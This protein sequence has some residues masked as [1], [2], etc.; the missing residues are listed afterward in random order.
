M[1]FDA[2]GQAQPYLAASVSSDA[3]FTTWTLKLRQGVRFH[4]GE[5][6]NADAVVVWA[7][8]LKASAIT[9]PAAQMLNDIMAVDPL[10][11]RMTTTKPWAALPALVTGQG[12][13]VVSPTQLKAEDGPTKPIGTGPFMLRDW[14]IDDH[15]ELVRNPNYWRP[16]LPYLDAVRFQVVADGRQRVAMLEHGD[17]DVSS[18]SFQWDL[19]SLDEATARQA[20]LPESSRFT[21]ARDPGDAEKDMIMFNTTKAPLDDVRIR[22]ALAYATD[23]P[24]IAKADGWPADVAKGPI[25]P[26]S[27]FY[28]DVAYPT[29]DLEKAKALV[30]EYQAEKRVK[31][32]SFTLT[33]AAPAQLMAQ[34]LL[35][36]WAKAGIKVR[37]TNV[38]VKQVVR[39]AVIGN[40]EASEF[41]YF[42][43][44]DP[45][46]FWHFFVSDTIRNPGVS[47]N[48]TQ[49]KDAQIDA[50]MNEARGTDNIATRK[51]AYALVQQRLA[52]Q[53][54]YLWL[55]RTE[56]RIASGAR[57]RNA[58]NVTLP[59]G[60]AAMPYVAGSSTLTETWIDTAG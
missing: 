42:A 22:R 9:G 52:D 11:V 5:P 29:F 43:A 3:T 49:F 37:L 1:A 31:E 47:L 12:G 56:W 50:G 59:D 14:K 17:L 6:L 19:K 57:V 60:R 13:Y 35:D 21:V 36:Q 27:P 26:T 48:F 28:A 44:P 51:R 55:L 7:K 4:N 15:F 54:P 10:T 30:R 18:F 24:A 39:Y 34:G 25:A 53:L 32:V 33:V 46:A 16:N 8:A 38:D 58:R 45:D 20:A 40:Y 2:N 41:R 23:V